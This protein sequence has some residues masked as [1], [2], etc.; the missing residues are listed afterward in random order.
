MDAWRKLSLMAQALDADASVD[1]VY[2]SDWGRIL[3]TLIRPVGDGEEPSA[4]DEL[5]H[6][7]SSQQTVFRLRG[8]RRG[9]LIDSLTEHQMPSSE[10]A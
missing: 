1:A 5:P 2:R 7:G 10:D 6:G 8:D 4:I 3:A 9:G